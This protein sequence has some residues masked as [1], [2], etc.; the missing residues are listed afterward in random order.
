VCSRKRKIGP[1][2]HVTEH[3]M[4]VVESLID[5]CC[6]A[7]NVLTCAVEH[8]ICVIENL[9]DVCCREPNVCYRAAHSNADTILFFLMFVEKNFQKKEIG[10]AHHVIEHHILLKPSKRRRHGKADDFL[11]FLCS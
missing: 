2:N 9:I 8:L 1:A 11:F 6:R 5:V 4:C 7:P 3:L 10:P